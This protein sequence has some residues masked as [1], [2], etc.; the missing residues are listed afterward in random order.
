MVVLAVVFALT[1]LLL[2][3]LA[4]PLMRRRVPPNGLYGLR[5]AATFADEE[6]WYEANARSAACATFPPTCCARS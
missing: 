4:V 3:G 5:V 2:A 1:G 6:V